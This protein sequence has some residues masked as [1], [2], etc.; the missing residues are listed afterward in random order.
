MGQQHTRW[1]APATLQSCFAGLSKVFPHNATALVALKQRVLQDLTAAVAAARG[2]EAAAVNA[3]AP[4]WGG[5]KGVPPTPP[6]SILSDAGFLRW[7]VAVVR[8][9]AR[10]MVRA[11]NMH[12]AVP[13]PGAPWSDVPLTPD[14]LPVP[15]CANLSDVALIERVGRHG[16]PQEPL[17]TIASVAINH[18]M[19][20][21]PARDGFASYGDFLMAR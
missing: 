19:C 16:Q 12:L 9:L 8:V 10:Y 11:D 20:T 3:S 1:P 4:W 14:D 2:V 6:R 13:C 7:Q 21:V 18:G 5:L 17:D 15:A